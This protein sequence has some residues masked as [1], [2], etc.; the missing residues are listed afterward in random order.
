MASFDW[1]K[2]IEDSLKDGLI[3]VFTTTTTVVIFF[4][5]RAMGVGQYDALVISTLLVWSFSL[6][7]MGKIM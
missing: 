3:I 4:A 1:K 7:V 2:N 5:L 6:P